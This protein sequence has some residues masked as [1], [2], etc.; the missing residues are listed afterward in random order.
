MLTREESLKKGY[1]ELWNL[2][3]RL[4]NISQIYYISYDGS[5]YLKSLLH[6]VEVHVTLRYPEKFDMFKGCVVK[7]NELFQFGK[8]LKISKLQV[9]EVSDENGYRI[10]F[11]QSDYPSLS[12][13]LH[14]VNPMKEMEDSYLQKQVRPNFYKRMFEL[15]DPDKYEHFE[16]P[17][18]PLD[19]DMVED[20]YDSKPVEFTTPYGD[21]IFLTR[22]MCLDI[23]RGDFF[24]IVKRARQQIP[25]KLN[26]YRLFYILAHDTDIYSSYTLYNRVK[27]ES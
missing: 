1:R 3:Q 24:Q 21:N 19:N 26:T 13:T 5:V 11:S 16:D 7:P 6:F 17:Y 10:I 2:N 12:Y 4:K 25:G 14:M 8:V 20:L 9:E 18:Y 15:N 27:K 22:Q 23:K